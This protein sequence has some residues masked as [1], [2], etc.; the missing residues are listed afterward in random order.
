MCHSGNT[1]LFVYE[2]PNLF[3]FAVQDENAEHQAVAKSSHILEK[4]KRR[5]GYRVVA[6]L[7]LFAYEVVF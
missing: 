5:Q 7:L 2:N 1:F 6:G 4:K 3:I